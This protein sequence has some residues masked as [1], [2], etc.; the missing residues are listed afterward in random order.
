M[1]FWEDWYNKLEINWKKV[2]I[3]AAVIAVVCGLIA[4][5]VIA[6]A[7]FKPPTATA[8]DA[9]L[10]RFALAAGDPAT[11]ST[12]SFNITATLSLKNPNIYR[13]ISYDPLPVSLSFN[14]TRFDESG[15]VPGFEHAARKTAT[16]NIKVGGVDKPIKLSAPG[17]KE[18]RA[19][20]ETGKF[21]V[22]LRLDTVMQYKGRST[23]CPLVVICPLELQLADPEVAATAFQRTKCTILRAKKSGC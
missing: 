5:L 6:F 13:S 1:A 3:W 23:K 18:F 14:G 11:N 8:N 10:E 4:V 2:A 12:V 9:V 19:E 15:K 17:V 21:D 7:V 20:N 16:F 22:E